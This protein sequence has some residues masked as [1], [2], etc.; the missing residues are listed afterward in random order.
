MDN[1]PDATAV[2][3]GGSDDAKYASN[4][5]DLDADYAPGDVDQRHR[6]VVSGYWDLGYWKDAGGFGKAVLGGWALGWIAS[7]ESGLP[8]SEV[9][10]NDVNRDGNTLN[11]IVPGSRNSHRLPSQYNV[12][13]RLIKRIP[14]GAKARLELIGEAFNLFNRTNVTAQRTTLYNFTN[15][16]LVL[17]QG[18]GNPRLNFGADSN[19]QLN[20]DSNARIVQLAGKITF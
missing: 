8:Y 16:A 14:L 7:A 10:A 1:K 11:D 4:P 18:L 20:F 17:Q 15:G 3:P 12:D 5:F 6:L 9:I 2:V 13:L 19:A